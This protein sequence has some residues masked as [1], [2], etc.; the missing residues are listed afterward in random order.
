MLRSGDPECRGHWLDGQRGPCEGLGSEGAALM[1]IRVKSL[2]GRR[3]GLQA[4]A[5]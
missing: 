1:E 2:P 3:T 4:L 5:G